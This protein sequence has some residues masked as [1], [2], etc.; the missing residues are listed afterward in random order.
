MELL[1]Q[2]DGQMINQVNVFGN[3]VRGSLNFD[4]QNLATGNWQLATSNLLTKSMYP[5]MFLYLGALVEHWVYL[6]AIH[7]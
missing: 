3:H 5:V 2:Q 6:V 7:Q 1:N 4:S